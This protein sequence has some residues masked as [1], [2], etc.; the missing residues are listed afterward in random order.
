MLLLLEEEKKTDQ[1]T[2]SVLPTV[3]TVLASGEVICGATT[4]R[5]SRVGLASTSSAAIAAVKKVVKRIVK[6]LIVK[7]VVGSSE[8]FE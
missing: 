2:V 5:F 1:V 3:Q 7:E 6:K 8:L 4:S